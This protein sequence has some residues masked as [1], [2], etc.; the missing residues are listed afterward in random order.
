MRAWCSWDEEEEAAVPKFSEAAKLP[1]GAKGAF[2]E[3]S[4]KSYAIQDHP[5]YAVSLGIPIIDGFLLLLPRASLS[6]FAA[7]I[8]L[9]F[10]GDDSNPKLLSSISCYP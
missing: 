6:S 7:A 9:A 2:L 1:P 8:L 5:L 10:V 4:L 3:G